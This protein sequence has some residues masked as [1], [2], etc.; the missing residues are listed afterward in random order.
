MVLTATWSS[1]EPEE[2]TRKSTKLMRRR[3]MV[4]KDSILV[5]LSVRGMWRGVVVL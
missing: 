1:L 4:F 2:K 3:E 5:A